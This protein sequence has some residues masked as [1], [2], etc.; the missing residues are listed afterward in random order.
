MDT[1]KMSDIRSEFTRQ[2]GLGPS[3]PSSRRG[4][5]DDKLKAAREFFG[6]MGPGTTSPSRAQMITEQS[7][8]QV[9]PRDSGGIRATPVLVPNAKMSMPSKKQMLRE[10]MMD[11]ANKRDAGF[12][13]EMARE[14]KKQ[15]REYSGY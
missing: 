11:T 6:E 7:G 15:Q 9:I 14:R 2:R 8:K 13:K 1:R 12:A 10:G 3:M 4:R 5:S